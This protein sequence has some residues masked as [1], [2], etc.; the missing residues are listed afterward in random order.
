MKYWSGAGYSTPGYFSVD[1][2]ETTN[3]FILNLF[4]FCLHLCIK[5]VFCVYF[6]LYYYY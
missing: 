6:E 3:T 5:F 2:F 4:Q 1:M